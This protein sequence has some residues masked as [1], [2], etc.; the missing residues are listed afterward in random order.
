MRYYGYRVTAV[1]DPCD[2]VLLLSDGVSLVKSGRF[3]VAL[4][5]SEPAGRD[6][7][8]RWIAEKLGVET[9]LTAPQFVWDGGRY[10]WALSVGAAVMYFCATEDLGRGTV[11]GVT[12]R[13]IAGLPHDRTQGTEA[14]RLIV[15][16]LA[17]RLS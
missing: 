11:D 8:V 16:H 9:G 3:F 1:T 13:N 2:G 5:L 12:Y 10:C 15:L 14:L 4:D 7:A 6:I 17:G